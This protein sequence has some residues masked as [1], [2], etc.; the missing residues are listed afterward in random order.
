LPPGE[1]RHLLA[2]LPA[3]V[4]KTLFPRPD[5]TEH[6][7][8]IRSA[9]QFVASAIASG[10]GSASTAQTIV[11]EVLAEVRRLVPEEVDD[12]AAVLPRELR[13]LWY[14][15]LRASH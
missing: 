9:E 13:E 3:D 14:G 12:I 11:G 8:R 2:H 1:R 6:A 7:S 5:A 10:I 15:A 4:R